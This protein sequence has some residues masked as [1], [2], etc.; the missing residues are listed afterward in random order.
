MRP[1]ARRLPS[2]PVV[3][4][5]PSV[6]ARSFSQSWAQESVWPSEP[7]EA[8]HSHSASTAASSSEISAPGNQWPSQP[9]ARAVRARPLLSRC[10]G[11]RGVGGTLEVSGCG[12]S[13]SAA[14]PC[15]ARATTH[16]TTPPRGTAGPPFDKLR[17]D[18]QCRPP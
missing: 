14:P 12:A 15:S 6:S 1:P 7:G 13:M 11:L 3:S 18:G 5:K 4:S 10:S 17:T 8:A 9:M 16:A 2:V